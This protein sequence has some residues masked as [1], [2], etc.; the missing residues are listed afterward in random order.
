MKPIVCFSCQ[1]WSWDLHW[2]LEIHELSLPSSL[3]NVR[4]CVSIY[5]SS[6]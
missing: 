3:W 2:N 6:C 5:Y 4:T 1:T